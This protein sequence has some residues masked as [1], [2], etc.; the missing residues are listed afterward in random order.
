[1]LEREKE[2]LREHIKKVGIARLLV[3]YLLVIIFII[4]VEVFASLNIYLLEG[5]EHSEPILR[6]VFSI[7]A[8]VVAVFTVIA[9]VVFAGSGSKHDRDFHYYFRIRPLMIYSVTAIVGDIVAVAL[10]GETSYIYVVFFTSMIALSLFSIV[11][12]VHTAESTFKHRKLS[13]A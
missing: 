2:L 9:N 1:M 8:I 3:T 10:A 5:S 6:D 13:Q 4:A 12:A 11:F 7:T